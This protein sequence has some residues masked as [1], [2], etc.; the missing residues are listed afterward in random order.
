MI[1]EKVVDTGLKTN[2]KTKTLSILNSLQ[3]LAVLG[4]I[5]LFLSLAY[6]SF[7]TSINLIN[8]VRQQVANLIAA[9]GMTFILINGEVDISIGGSVALTSVVIAKTMQQYGIWPALLIGMCTGIL[10]CTVNAVVILEGRIPS[11]IA[12]LG[13]MYMARSLAYVYTKNLFIAGLPESFISF[14]NSK[15][16]HI[17][18]VLIIVVVVYAIAHIA[19][20]RTRYGR[21]IFAVGSDKDISKVMGINVKKVKYI[22]FI[23]LGVCTGLASILLTSRLTGAQ[24]NT[25]TGFEFEVIS[26]VII[27]GASLYGGVANILN[28]IVGVFIIALIRNGL[29]LSHTDI[30]WQN[31]VLGFVIVFAVF[32]DTWRTRIKD[33]KLY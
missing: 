15:I 5:F 22:S 29:N 27:G 2:F 9:A 17:P 26:A 32:L 16:F 31:F 23:V 8:I 10:I 6:P 3:I 4:L 18:V 30:Y 12:T 24:A 19:L 25:A 33:R 11:F 7:F 14:F 1:S 13:M 20:T 28:T 21:Y